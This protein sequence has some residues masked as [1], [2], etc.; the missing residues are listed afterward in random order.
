MYVCILSEAFRAVTFRLPFDFYRHKRR[1]ER[2]PLH[3][4][5]RLQNIKFQK[6]DHEQGIDAQH[7]HASEV[8]QISR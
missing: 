8:E 5:F 2:V 4:V 6:A 1:S 3:L 7:R